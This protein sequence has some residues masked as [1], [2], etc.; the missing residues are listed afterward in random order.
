MNSD[1]LRID[2]TW[3]L[4]LDRDGVINRR[5]IDGYVTGW[6]EF[7]FLPGVFQAIK[8]F[9]DIF[10]RIIVVS[11]QQGVGKGLMTDD[12]VKSIHSKMVELITIH[13]GRIDQT[14]FC[15]DLRDSGSINRKPAPGM[16][17]QAKKDYPEIDFNR[18][19]MVGDLISDALFGKSL[20]MK[21]VLI[22][23]EVQIE[24]QN[25]GLIDMVFPGL[26]S[27]SQYLIK[28]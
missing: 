21:T 6:S 19:V 22:T 11:N 26:L 9:S 5:I 23:D 15:G 20:K 10:S 25:S 16:A 24:E 13:G 27:F 7:E 1:S 17:H 18:S 2:H 3:T 12:T 4:F 28:T 8:T 14:Y